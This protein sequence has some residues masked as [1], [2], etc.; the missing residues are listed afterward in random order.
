MN[1][2]PLK[3][4]GL[5]SAVGVD[6]ALCMWLGYKGGTVLDVKFGTDMVWSLVGLMIGLLTGIFTVI[7]LIKRVTGDENNV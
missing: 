3:A 4:M 6:L 1:D 5:V 7:L 2:N